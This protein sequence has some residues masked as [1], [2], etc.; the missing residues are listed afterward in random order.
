MRFVHISIFLCKGNKKLIKKWRF[1]VFFSYLCKKYRDKAKKM[2]ESNDYRKEL[3]SRIVNYAMN[4]F[5]KRGI[6]AVKM[7]EISQGLHVSKRT[8]YEIFGDK[9]ELL[10]EGLKDGDL[11]MRQ[12]LEEYA[13]IGNHNVIDIL[14][15]FY[16]IQMQVN[17]Q[18][19]ATFYEEIHK[20]PRVVEYLQQEHDR[21]HDDR[22]RFLE[23]GV[24]EGLFRKDINYRLA[25][26]LIH[27]SM[28]EIMH[29]QLYKDFPMPEIFDNYFLVIIRGFCTERGLTLL[30]KAIE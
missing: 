8:V 12:Q 5:C 11:R 28:G 3:K 24:K 10:L 4:E 30:N 14:G 20:M 21:M 29:R 7:D 6:K 25:L 22:I 13:R 19:G 17:G 1:F 23:A 9:E 27:V 26:E 18:V 2:S 16:K 15:Y